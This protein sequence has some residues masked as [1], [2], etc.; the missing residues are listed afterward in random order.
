MCWPPR[1]RAR[2]L[3]AG[4]AFLALGLAGCAL[5][6]PRTDPLQAVSQGI[7]GGAETRACEWP[8]VVALG[9][10]SG[11]L[12]HPSLVVYAAH[13]GLAMAEV[14]FGPDS[15]APT[16][17]AEVN[18]CHQY[19]G[20]QLGDGSDLA[21]CVLREPVLDIQPARILAG[22][23]LD[24]LSA[25]TAAHIVGFGVATAG[26][27]F[28][29]QRA[30][31]TRVARV[32]AGELF[33]DSSESDTCR[34]DS[35]GPVFIELATSTAS[36]SAEL[37]LAGVTSAGSSSECGQGVSHY[38]NLAPKLDWLESS[39]GIDVT[40]CFD[41]D[42][43]NPTP[44]CLTV[45][46][47]RPDAQ[48]AQ[49]AQDASDAHDLSEDA[50][51]QMP[52]EAERSS[53]C[54]EAFAL[55]PDVEPPLIELAGIDDDSVIHR[56]VVGERYL[57]FELALRVED[58]GWGVQHVGITLLGAD[59][60]P[61]FE[62]VDQVAPYGI[63]E[64]RVPPGTFE[65]L[66][67]ARDHAGNSSARAVQLRVISPVSEPAGCTVT[68]YSPTPGN[69][70]PISFALSLLLLSIRRAACLQ[71]WRKSLVRSRELR[72]RSCARSAALLG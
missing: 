61:L 45:P 57:A 25:G 69:A 5:A 72:R 52:A 17:V 53:T 8:A 35:G 47:K 9:G 55:P 42:G 26:A 30:A 22:C 15:A 32:T 1:P 65:L 4:P 44:A 16:R 7:T 58:G 56:L 36:G 71:Q 13:C 28:G 23:E 40:P 54:G 48:D 2:I 11:T 60:A 24:A 39:S 33:L 19:P 62:R 50:S 59:A 51:C 29:T 3:H 70:G 41:A 43:W 66:I 20:A 31:S 46:G 63:E 14:R 10:C 37:R 34:G 68:P 6:P 21:Y 18:Q 12:V 27:D 38:V 49:D 67:E 64:L